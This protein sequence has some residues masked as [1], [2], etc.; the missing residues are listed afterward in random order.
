[1]DGYSAHRRC[2]FDLL[3]RY[4][5]QPAAEEEVVQVQEQ[6]QEQE[7]EQSKEVPLYAEEV[8][9]IA[10]TRIVQHSSR[11]AGSPSM[12]QIPF[13]PSL[14]Y[15]SHQDLKN[16]EL[17]EYLLAAAERVGD[18]QFHHAA[19]LLNLCDS[20]SSKT[21]NPV[22]RLGHCFTR[23]LR[24]RISRDMGGV[25][26]ILE[27]VATASKIHVIDLKIRN[28]QHWVALIQG[29]VS[30]QSDPT[31]PQPVELLRITAV[32]TASDESLSMVEETGNRLSDFALTMN[33]PFRFDIVVMEDNGWTDFKLDRFGLNRNEEALVVYSEWGL[34][35][36]IA[37]PREA[38][39][40]MKTLKQMN[41]KAMVTIEVEANLNSPN[42][43]GRFVEALFHYSAVFENIECGGKGRDDPDRV[44][45]E[46]V[47]LGE[48]ISNILASEGEERYMRSVKIG[49][50]RKFFGQFGMVEIE[51]SGAAMHQAKLF[52]EK[53]VSGQPY[54]IG[55]DGKSMV[56]GF[57]STPMICVSTWK[58]VQLARL[59]STTTTKTS[60]CDLSIYR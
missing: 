13:D 58:F 31:N 29:L 59:A 5:F 56:L 53:F 2:N 30:R 57:R 11:K 36:L 32:E 34:R 42:F 33:V 52:M 51:P 18:K 3:H 45:V 60:F 6:E 55:M 48:K 7:Q 19:A 14:N 49:V 47:F 25:Q 4:G 9:R 22:Q 39:R 40:V 35:R 44:T 8:V 54:T 43:S 24:H 10:G 17:A 37:M 27:N 28:G 16:V 12:L 20:L 21:G 41:P 26:A 15:L 38:E 1:M 23:A 50:W 46:T